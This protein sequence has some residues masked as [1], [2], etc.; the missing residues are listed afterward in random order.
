M[1]E[2]ELAIR[3]SSIAARPPENTILQTPMKI[4]WPGGHKFAFTAVDDTDW[5]TARQ[6]Q[7]GLRPAGE[8]RHAHDEIRVDVRRARQRRLPGPDLRRPRTTWTGSFSL[9]KAGFEISL[10]NAAPVTSRRERTREAL[11][12]FRQLFGGGDPHALQ[13]PH[14]RG[15]HL[16]G[17]RPRDGPAPLG[18]QLVYAQW[19]PQ[20]LPRPHRG[21]P[22]VLGRPLPRAR[23]LRAQFRVR[24]DQYPQGLPPDAVFR[25]RASRT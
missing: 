20:P 3:G 6:H 14:V 9:R 11:D 13:P 4:S 24:R 19:P 18:L 25:S 22:A 17:R 7:T 5:S 15:E 12:R 10:H 23:R 21:R 1:T 8:P 2:E 16:L